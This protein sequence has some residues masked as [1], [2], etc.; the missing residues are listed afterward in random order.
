MNLPP[1]NK[2]LRPV[3]QDEAKLSVVPPEFSHLTA[4]EA[5]NADIR[6]ILLSNS[7]LTDA[8]WAP[9]RA[10]AFLSAS[11]GL[12]S[13]S[14]YSKA[15]TNRLLSERKKELLLPINEITILKIF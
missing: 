13:F 11:H 9:L 6:R 8:Q 10:I 2:K 12:P 15:R 7:F 14:P 3:K 1:I 4:L 5:F